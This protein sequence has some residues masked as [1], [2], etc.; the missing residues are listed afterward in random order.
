MKGVMKFVAL[1]PVALACVSGAQSDVD[2]DGVD[3]AIDVCN[4][5]P[6]GTAVSGAST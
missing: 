2:G 5:T 1:V 3:D 6:P 4:N